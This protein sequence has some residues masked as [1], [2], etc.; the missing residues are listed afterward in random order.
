M[1]RANG[2]NLITAKKLADL[3]GYTEGALRK[4]IHDGIFV[5]GVHFLKSPDGRIHFDLQEYEKWV[6]HGQPE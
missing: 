6:R 2:L 5:Q 1:I 4:K 3:S